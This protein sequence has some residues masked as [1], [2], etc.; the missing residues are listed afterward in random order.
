MTG[1]NGISRVILGF[2]FLVFVAR[3]LSPEAKAVFKVFLK[4]LP[5]VFHSLQSN[6]T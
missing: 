6:K 5:K 3:G 1:I 2:H 4:T